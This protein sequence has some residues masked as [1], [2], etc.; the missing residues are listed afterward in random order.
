MKSVKVELQKLN[1]A[2]YSNIQQVLDVEIE[3]KR[4]QDKV[5]DGCLDSEI[6]IEER[7]IRERYQ[8]L[9]QAEESFFQSKSRCT[10]LELGDANTK[11][12]HSAMLVSQSRNK[13][14]TIKSGEGE[15][16]EEPNEVVKEAVQFFETEDISRF[17]ERQVP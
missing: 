2:N 16:I 15:L 8:K 7:N 6:L 14:C 1:K 5:Y 11:H 4:V 9:C 10:W 12:F 13:I 17:N 3:L